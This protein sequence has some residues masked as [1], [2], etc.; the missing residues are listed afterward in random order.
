MSA[1]TYCRF[2]A[3]HL[4]PRQDL[5]F[6]RD[7]TIALLRRYFQMAIDLGRLPSLLGREFF[8]AKVTSYKRTSF[9]DSVI[10]VHDIERCFEALDEF[11]QILIARIVLQNYTQE[12]A[13]ALLGCTDRSIRRNFPEAID[14]LTALFLDRRILVSLP[15]HSACQ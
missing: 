2:P 11:S 3:R 4:T 7:R 5:Y 12:E 15:K 13:A 14:E 8:R 1:P 9:E 10:F 6:Y